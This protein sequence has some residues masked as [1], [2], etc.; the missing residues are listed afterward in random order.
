MSVTGMDRDAPLR[1]GDENFMSLLGV[2]L[3]ALRT[4]PKRLALAMLAFALILVIAATAWEQIRLNAWNQPFYDALA[5]KDLPTVLTQLQVYV[6]IAGGLLILN[7]SQTWLA[8]MMKLRLRE[9]LTCDLIG[10]W[11]APKRAVLLAQSGEI[12]V[13]PDQRIHAD[14][15]HL[16]DISADLGVGLVQASLLLAS[17]IG[18]LWILSSGVVFDIAGRH[19]DVP[20]Y[21]VWCALIY[22][23]IGSLASWWVG[24][25]LMALGA[26][27]YARESDVRFALV[28]VSEHSE[29]IAL[30]GGETREAH[31]L[32]H[33]FAAL[34][35]ILRKL[36]GATTNLTWVSAGYGWVAIVAPLIV[37]APAYFFGQLSF[38]GLLMAAGA[39]TQVQQS[40]RWF[41]DNAGVI[42]DWRA[43]LLRVAVFRRALLE[44][45]PKEVALRAPAVARSD[46]V[47]LVEERDS[48]LLENVVLALPSRQTRLDAPRIEMGPGARVHIVGEHGCGKTLLFRA[49][50]G[51]WRAGGGRILTPP[52]TR[53]AFIPKRA[54]IPALSLR[55]ILSYP[56]PAST[57]SDE[58]T[59]AALA[60]FN[61][62]YLAAALDRAGSW[63]RELA[64]PERQA[65]VFA[66]L[67]LRRP[68]FVVIDEAIDAL[69]P[70]AKAIV[71]DIFN[72]E[73]KSSALI[74]I[75]GS[76]NPDP[77]F[78]R[79]YHLES[80]PAAET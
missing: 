52:E 63:D 37:A 74:Y 51:L 78:T 27:R 40:L 30:M 22:A 43:T 60:R 32:A 75:S 46:I 25:P 12:G 44:P 7:V 73:L 6:L 8:Q 72:R 23:L 69:S 33:T 35:E 68:D 41:V 36:V 1:T 21:M 29:P 55:E 65:I 9:A 5:Q 15:Q 76:R 61:L 47:R 79:S 67:L 56:A 3:A 58:E 57:Y 4:T 59:N 80:F 62:D 64:D 71:G 49:L 31:R 17:F 14:A 39:F 19:I 70:D 16:A 26:E 28:E 2:V 77:L 53:I 48:F 34:V 10:L 20:G 54:Y 42:A 13:N 50:A 45:S 11:L 66:R 38:G 24:R 18:V